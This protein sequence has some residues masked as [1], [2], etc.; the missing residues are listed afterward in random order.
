MQ[1]L[2]PGGKAAKRRPGTA[3]RKAQLNFGKKL[4]LPPQVAGQPQII[5]GQVPASAKANS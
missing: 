2:V 3:G 4:G 1:L 5:L